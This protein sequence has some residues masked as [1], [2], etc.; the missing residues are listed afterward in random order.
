M[1]Y[2]EST[3]GFY[4]REIHGDNMPADV[5]EITTEEHAALLAGQSSGKRIVADPSGRPFLQDPPPMTE[6]QMREAEIAQDK[7]Y[8][9]S[10]DYIVTKIAEASALGQDTPPLLQQY[11]AELEQRELAR[12]RIRINEGRA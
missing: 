9:A 12:V 10:T 11:A 5:V 7:A 6:E 2:S 1:Y 8:L 3:G 4:S